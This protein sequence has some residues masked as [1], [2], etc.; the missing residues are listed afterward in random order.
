MKKIFAVFVFLG[1]AFAQP[2]FDPKQFE[3][4]RPMFELMSFPMLTIEM[5]K[6]K[7]LQIAKAQAK[8][9]L[10][11]LESLPARSEFT[12]KEADKILIQLEKALSRQQ[13]TWLDGKR[14]AQGSRPPTGGGIPNP[15]EF[16]FIQNMLGGKP[17]NPFRQQRLAGDLKKLTDLLRKR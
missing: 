17:V 2:G 3:A 12:S 4:V 5:D 9:L 7:G 16:T 11:T 13:L 1:L 14:A 15:A 8:K 10:P 6:Q